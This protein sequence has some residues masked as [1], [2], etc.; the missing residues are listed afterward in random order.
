MGAFRREAARSNLE[1]LRAEPISWRIAASVLFV[2]LVSAGFLFRELLVRRTRL[3]RRRWDTVIASLLG[4]V[5]GAVP[6]AFGYYL[7]SGRK[8]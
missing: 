3:T 6:S 4:M 8:G 1:D 5:L 2:P 7:V